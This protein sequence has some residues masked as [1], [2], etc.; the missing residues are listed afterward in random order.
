MA[1]FTTRVELHDGQSEDYVVLHEAME[2]Q[3]F[4]REIA[5][6]DGTIYEMPWAEYNLIADTTKEN[7]LERAKVAA[8]KTGCDFGILVTEGDRTWHGLKVVS[9]PVRR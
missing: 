6:S 9:R 5:S 4:S 8:T 3:G 1:K 7:V 2:A